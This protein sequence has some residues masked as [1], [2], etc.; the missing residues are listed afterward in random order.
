M[1]KNSIRD[2]ELWLLSIHYANKEKL[3]EFALEIGYSFN[4]YLT[5]VQ[6]YLTTG[7]IERL[8]RDGFHFSAHSIDHPEYRFVEFSEQIRQPKESVLHVTEKFFLNYKLF[9]SHSQITGFQTDFLQLLTMK[10]L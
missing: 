5:S 7:Q 1:A 2:I 4:K 3:D 8:I 10:R 9:P 6:P